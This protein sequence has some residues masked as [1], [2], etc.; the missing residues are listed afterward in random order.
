MW[1]YT[2]EEYDLW[3]SWKYESLFGGSSFGDI[4]SDIKIVRMYTGEDV[5]CKLKKTGEGFVQIDDAVV[6]VPTQQN[7]VQFI[8]WSPFSDEKETITVAEDKVV[9]ITEPRSDFVNQH[10]QMFGGIVAPDQKIIV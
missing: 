6:I 9:F 7:S 10:K 3:F 4:M 2:N 8:P 1:P 5:L